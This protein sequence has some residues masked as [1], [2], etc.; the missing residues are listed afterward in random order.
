MR[1]ALTALSLALLLPSVATAQ[2]NRPAKGK[3]PK[4]VELKAADGLQIRGDL[5]A[6]GNKSGPVILLCHQARSSRGEYR[7]IAPRL[8]AAGYTCLAL[9]Q[10]S[11]AEWEGV[12][13]E[14]A[15]RA[16]AAG[17]TADYLSARQDIEAGIKW[18]RGQGYRGKLALW[19]SS[20]SASLVLVVGSKSK[21]VSAVLSFSP[22]EYFRPKK[23]FVR[24]A[25]GG[26]AKKPVLIVSPA[27]E[28][29]QAEPIG[30]AIPSAKLVIDAKILHGS[31]TLVRSPLAET[32]W[33]RDVLPF[34]KKAL[35]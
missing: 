10:R 15:R 6:T 29:K 30:A 24:S 17:K 16:K 12:A 21:E 1:L 28:R 20:Y 5:Y 2:A 11:G 3:G 13:N 31:R 4:T 14:T 26:L 23:D 18:L 8:Q 7:K 33:T 27:K 9:D 35:R 19:G 22:G 32:L 34:L 25:V